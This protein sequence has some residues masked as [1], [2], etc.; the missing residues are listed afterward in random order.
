MD[1]KNEGLK[2]LWHS[3]QIK[4]PFMNNLK[5]PPRKKGDWVKYLKLLLLEAEQKY[6]K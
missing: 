2:N 3:S 5:S 4:V 6:K 1:K